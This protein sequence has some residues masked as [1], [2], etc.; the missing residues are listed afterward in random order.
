MLR[1]CYMEYYIDY[2]IQDFCESAKFLYIVDGAFW[3]DS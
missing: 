2:F 3:E 1:G